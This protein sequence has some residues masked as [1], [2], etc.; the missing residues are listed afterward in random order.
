MPQS[1]SVNDQE[2]FLTRGFSRRQ[3]GRIASALTAGAA[4]PFYNEAAFA[5]RAMRERGDMS[6]AVRINSNENPLGPCPE[7]L[8]AICQVA[9]FGGR[10][11]PHDE[12][13][14]LTRTVASLEGLKPDY[15]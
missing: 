2:T 11:S 13:G 1:L 9:K 14:E 12:Q 6:E 8:E 15:I 4:L 7:A 5:Q 10:Y 3:L